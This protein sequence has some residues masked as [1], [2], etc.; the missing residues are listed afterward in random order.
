MSFRCCF[1]CSCGCYFPWSAVSSHTCGDWAELSL[2]LAGEL[3][4]CS[5]PLSVLC[6]VNSY[7]CGLSPGSL[8]YLV[9]SKRHRDDF[10]GFVGWKLSPSSKMGQWCAHL[11]CFLPLFCGS[12]ATWCLVYKNCFFIYFILVFS[13]F[14]WENKSGL[15][16]KV[17][18]LCI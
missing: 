2:R 9:K 8:F 14:V 5:S 11:I 6:H 4:L 17:E 15:W 13:C 1:L 16:L 10:G 12:C 7:H 3:S 18:V